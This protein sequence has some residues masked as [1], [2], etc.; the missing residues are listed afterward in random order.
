MKVEHTNKVHTINIIFSPLM[1]LQDT[2]NRPYTSP[3]ISNI[4]RIVATG[5]MIAESIAMVEETISLALMILFSA[6]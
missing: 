2:L 4:T 1:V 6:I 3:K 5:K